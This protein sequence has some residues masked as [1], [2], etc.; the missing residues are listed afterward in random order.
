MMRLRKL[1][2]Y[3]ASSGSVDL[4]LFKPIHVGKGLAEKGVEFDT[5]YIGINFL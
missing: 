5:Y 3:V 1:K 4:C 2:T